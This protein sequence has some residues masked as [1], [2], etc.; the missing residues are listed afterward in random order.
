MVGG[1]GLPASEPCLGGG[2]RRLDSPYHEALGFVDLASC[3]ARGL[4]CLALPGPLLVNC[5]I[6]CLI[7]TFFVPFPLPMPRWISL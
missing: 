5:L 2:P 4:P 3:L 1:E 6:R 7:M